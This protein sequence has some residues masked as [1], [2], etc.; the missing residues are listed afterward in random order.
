MLRY[1]A[2]QRKTN[3]FALCL[4]SLGYIPLGALLAMLYLAKISLIFPYKLTKNAVQGKAKQTVLLCACDAL[5]QSIHNT[6]IIT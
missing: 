2:A 4:R 5:E 6:V 3:W 1:L